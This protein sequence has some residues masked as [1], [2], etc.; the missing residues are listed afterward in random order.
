MSKKL[1]ENECI[2]LIADAMAKEYGNSIKEEDMDMRMAISVY[3][4]LKDFL[5]IYKKKDMSKEDFREWYKKG[6]IF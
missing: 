6:R 1:G 3:K 4:K 5:P 2:V